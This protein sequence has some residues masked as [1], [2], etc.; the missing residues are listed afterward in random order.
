MLMVQFE[1]IVKVFIFFC[2]D[3]LKSQFLYSVLTETI[4]TPIDINF[5][6]ICAQP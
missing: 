1:P 4:K 6:Y 2:F 3:G 5:G